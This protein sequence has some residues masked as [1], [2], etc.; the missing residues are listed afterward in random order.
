SRKTKKVVPSAARA[1][2]KTSRKKTAVASKSKAKNQRKGLIHH[3]KRLYR[4]TPKF[5][6]GMVVGAFVGIILVTQFGVKQ[7]VDA[8]TIAAG[9]DCDS[10]SIIN[11]GVTSSG[12][13]QNKYDN[14][15]Y[16]RHVY[17]H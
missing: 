12:D 1:R 14:A 3:S 2:A 7:N 5:I 10:Y 11:C 4:V 17:Q 9:K 15:P 6:H 13:L 8:L 16:V